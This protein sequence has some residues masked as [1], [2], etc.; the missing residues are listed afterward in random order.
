M[1]I[2]LCSTLGSLEGYSQENKI[3]IDFTLQ[4]KNMH[5]WRGQQVTSAAL[6][7][8]DLN[9]KDNKKRFTLG[10]WGGAGFNG[11]YKEFD[12]YVSFEKSGFSIAVWDIYN[13]SDDVA[14][15]N[16]QMFN[17][18]ADQTGHFIDVAVAYQLQG[19][20]PL[21]MSWA[22]VL[23]GRDRGA[24]N[25]KNLY[26]TY[27]SVDCPVLKHN[28]VNLDFGIAGA[29]ALNKESGT[30]ANFYGNTAGIVNINVTASK[31]LQ[32]GKYKLPV[33][34]MA[35]WNPE[36]NSANLQLAVDLF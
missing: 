5:L 6:G 19:K 8:V 21:K 3:P 36:N 7:A 28:V 32:L 23:Y 35:M 18:R 29:F 27:V 4:V 30:K 20:L 17:Y 22:T 1:L 10:L 2:A 26:S 34:V 9:I 12:Y 14:H 16:S 25:E 24:L 11:K 33:A 13:F 15:N 31:V